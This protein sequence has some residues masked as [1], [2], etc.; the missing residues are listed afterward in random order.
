MA[1]EFSK[2]D[3][4]M[5]GAAEG[6][7]IASVG[8][9][10][11]GCQVRTCDKGSG[12]LSFNG[13]GRRLVCK[14]RDADFDSGGGDPLRCGLDEVRSLFLRRGGEFF[15]LRYGKLLL[16]DGAASDSSQSREHKRWSLVITNHGS[17]ATY[18]DS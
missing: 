6:R 13:T 12:G 5:E 7:D 2:V 11:V 14:G 1:G 10:L 3:D 17:L 8:T 4:L 18:P 16:R 15:A 9:G